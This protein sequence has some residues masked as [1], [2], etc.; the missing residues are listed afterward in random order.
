MNRH[1]DIEW[2]ESR[3]IEWARYMK[4]RPRYSTCQSLEGRFVVTQDERDKNGW[5]DVAPPEYAPP[6]NVRRAL[7]THAAIGLLP[8]SQKWALTYGYCYPSLDRWRVLKLM[9]KY[10]GRRFTWTAYLTEIEIGKVRVA[11]YLLQPLDLVA[12]A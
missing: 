10:S 6:V 4:D 2:I 12:C 7:Q 5:G 3:L 1:P 8:K 11:G 9:R